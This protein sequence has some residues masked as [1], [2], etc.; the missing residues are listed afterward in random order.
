M[1]PE[2]YSA[3]LLD[4]VSREFAQPGDDLVLDQDT[5]LVQSGILDS[6][7]VAV[8]MSFIQRELGVHVP[9]DKIDGQHFK[10]I[11]TIS[12]MLADESADGVRA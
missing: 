3:A 7:R 8:L 1:E 11:R 4:F 6:L 12:E 9:F 5:P 10:D 2:K